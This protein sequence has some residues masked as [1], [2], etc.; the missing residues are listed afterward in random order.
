LERSGKRSLPR[1]SAKREGGLKRSISD[2]A[3][4]CGSARQRKN[5]ILLRLSETSAE[6][7][8]IGFTEDLQDRL[9]IHNSG[10]VPYTA[11]F[12]PWKI[13]TA[14]AFTERERAVEFE[15]YL[16]SASGRAFAKKRL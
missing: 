1:R 5:E 15:C 4:S 3:P 16:K 11:K 6:H 10:S 2:D 9:K 12:R 13:K 14:I 7:F 8:Y